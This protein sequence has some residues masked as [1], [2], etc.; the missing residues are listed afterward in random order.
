MTRALRPLIA[1]TVLTALAIGCAVDSDEKLETSDSV[2]V[3]VQPAR[4][5][6]IRDSVRVTGIVSPAPGAELLITAPGSARILEMPKS[7]G[8]LVRK[9]DLLVRFEIPSLAAD[10]AS[11]KSDL[12]RAEA[13]RQTARSAATRIES[14]LE[15]GIAARREVEDARRELADAE[16]A[17]SETQ[18][19][20]Q[21]STL[22]LQRETVSAPFTGVV[23]RRWHN[24]GDLVESS[25]ADPILRIIDPSR[26]QVEISVPVGE[27]PRVRVDNPAQV[28]GPGAFP[29]EE[30]TVRSGPAAVDPATG[31]ATVRIAF[32]RPARLPAGTP[33][34]VVVF[35]EEHRGALLVPEGAVVH[36]G[37][38]SFLF[39]VD[40]ES[41]AR[42]RRVE[43]GITGGGDAE[44]LSGIG[45]N[46]MVVVKGQEALPD[47]AAVTTAGS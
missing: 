19:A 9:G 18:A 31:S 6:A 41:R 30:A 27:L 14:L 28:I 4:R 23:A 36:E 15:R 22:L 46:E 34:Q 26:L 3:T 10:I 32:A 11:K 42:R 33:V 12:S 47:G 5:G 1:A 13:R 20:V 8:D 37:P 25:S 43:V 7:E 35:G 29:P 40:D 17:V 16:A 44:I 2:T 45:D 39:T 24:P 38:E 21:A